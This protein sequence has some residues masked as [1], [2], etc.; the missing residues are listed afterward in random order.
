MP[1]GIDEA[2]LLGPESDATEGGLHRGPAI[3]PG[4]D[5]TA[6]FVGALHERF[7]RERA[8]ERT[9]FIDGF[10]RAPAN[11]GFEATLARVEADLRAAGFGSSDG[12]LLEWLEQ[13]MK[14][15]GGGAAPA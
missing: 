15:R 9:Q 1:R 2:V 13:P 6:R 4:S 11:D 3:V 8:F 14:A 10:Y 12:L 5:G 7:D